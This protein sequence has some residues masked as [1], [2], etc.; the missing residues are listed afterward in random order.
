MDADPVSGIWERYREALG[1]LGA[2]VNDTPVELDE[3]NRAAGY[4]HLARI[5]YMGLLSVHD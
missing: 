4:R 1:S 5:L 3:V 2:L